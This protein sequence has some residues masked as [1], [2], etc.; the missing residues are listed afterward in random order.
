LITASAKD[1]VLVWDLV[2]K[3][4]KRRIG[5]SIPAWGFG[6]SEDENVLACAVGRQVR[7][8]EIDTGEEL[9]RVRQHFTEET[10]F[11]FL[12][13]GHAICYGK[14][15]ELVV[16]DLGK[17]G[18]KTSITLEE[19]ISSLATDRQ[20]KLVACGAGRRV[21]FL[22][23]ESG[24]RK[25]AIEA[26]GIISQIRFSDRGELL[27]IM[28]GRTYEIWD[29]RRQR[30]I[31]QREPVF[32]PVL[33]T[34]DL[35]LVCFRVKPDGEEWRIERPL[36]AWDRI[37]GTT[38]HAAQMAVAPEGTVVAGRLF[39]PGE[40]AV[41]GRNGIVIWNGLE[42]TVVGKVIWDG[43]MVT[44]LCFSN[45]GRMVCL[46]SGGRIMSWEVA[47][48]KKRWEVESGCANLY[49]PLVSPNGK[50]LACASTDGNCVVVFDLLAA[51]SETR[52][53]AGHVG[54]IDQMEFSRDSRRLMTR[55]RDGTLKI[56]N[57][58]GKWANAGKR[59]EK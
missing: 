6:L 10:P 27:G 40:L 54:P 28:A 59:E 35:S 1:G 52:K 8:W 58:A 41:R 15:T 18:K 50:M 37:D 48:G 7:V 19:T 33:A 13:N 36:S 14:D 39:E 30:R 53:C 56:W 4:V 26:R 2:T 51:N 23:V 12:K 49:S 44:D 47:S 55:S 9:L 22:D 20:G 31:W 42:R 21:W 57:M 45:D 46:V 29:I 34:T 16:M 11:G 24:D 17:A 32:G 25:G 3:R 38:V 43:Q 5:R